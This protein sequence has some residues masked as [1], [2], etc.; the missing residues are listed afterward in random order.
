MST[1]AVRRS[2]AGKARSRGREI[3]RRA[4]PAARMEES[5]LRYRTADPDAMRG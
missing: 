3:V 4:Q 5:V 2:A 1:R